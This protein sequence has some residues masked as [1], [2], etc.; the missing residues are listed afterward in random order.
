MLAAFPD[1]DFSYTPGAK[2]HFTGVD[3]ERSLS[4]DQ[5]VIRINNDDIAE[6]C[7]S[8]ICTLQ[9]GSV[10]SVQGIEPNRVTI[11]ICDDDGEP[12]QVLYMI[13]LLYIFVRTINDFLLHYPFNP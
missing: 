11:E 6:P 10:D 8:F 7:E 2:L 13:V 3:T 5:V 4:I 1:R 9:G 12:T